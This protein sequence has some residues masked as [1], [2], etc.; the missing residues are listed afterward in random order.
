MNVLDNFNLKLKVSTKNDPDEVSDSDNLK[1]GYEDYL[2]SDNDD[3]VNNLVYM[4]KTSPSRHYSGLAT[5]PKVIYSHDGLELG[6]NSH[7][8][9][10]K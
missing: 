1:A 6:P 10:G 2:T 8:V 4:T 7:P 9:T 5:Q 3:E